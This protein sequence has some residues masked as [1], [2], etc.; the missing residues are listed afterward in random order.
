[1]TDF[2][3]GDH[4]IIG[5]G[6]VHWEVEHVWRLPPKH[7]GEQVVIMRSPMSQR[8]RTELARYVTLY[9]RAEAPDLASEG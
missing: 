8:R 5:Q 3:P 6:K 1:M 2:Q 4:V 7:R 9:R